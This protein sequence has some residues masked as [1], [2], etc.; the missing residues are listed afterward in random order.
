VVSAFVVL[1][2]VAALGAAAYIAADRLGVNGIRPW[3]SETASLI[4]QTIRR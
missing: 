1:G 2:C 3:L 4:S